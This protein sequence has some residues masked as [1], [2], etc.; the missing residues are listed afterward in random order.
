MSRELLFDTHPEIQRLG[1]YYDGLL[2]EA[3]KAR[4]QIDSLFRDFREEVL[5]DRLY[6]VEVLSKAKNSGIRSTLRSRLRTV[7][8][9]LRK[10]MIIDRISLIIERIEKA[11]K[12]S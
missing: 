7:R 3:D 4:G 8:K 9:D 10:P 12:Q 11:P 2:S 6:E 5:I 1:R